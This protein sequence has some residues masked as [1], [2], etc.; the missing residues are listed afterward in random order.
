MFLTG[1]LDWGWVVGGGRALGRS[2][3]E[4]GLGFRVGAITLRLDDPN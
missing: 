3:M 2:V 1:G 4:L